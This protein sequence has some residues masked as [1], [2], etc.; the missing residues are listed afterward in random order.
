MARL[1]F[2][3]IFLKLV[4]LIILFCSFELIKNINEFKSKLILS[5]QN[6]NSNSNNK[7]NHH[8]TS[9]NKK[10]VNKSSSKYIIIDT[11]DDY[12]YKNHTNN[13]TFCKIELNTTNRTSNLLKLP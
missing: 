10:I 6:S 2:K 8:I 13:A 5:V 7:T 1:N 11:F 3:S 4:L 9:R 12:Q